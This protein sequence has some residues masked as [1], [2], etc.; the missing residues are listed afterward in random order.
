KD[1]W[2]YGEAIAGVP[3]ALF[4]NGLICGLS[5]TDDE[6]GD[7]TTFIGTIPAT[8]VTGMTMHGFWGLAD[9]NA[10]A[11]AIAGVS[12][13]A[14]VDFALSMRAIG[15]AAGGRL[16]WRGAGVFEMVLTT[17]GVVVGAYESSFSRR[18]Q[19]PW[20]FLTAWSGAL[21]LHGL[22]SAIVNGHDPKK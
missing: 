15:R 10:P 6:M 16:H 1:S 4:F 13:L 5:A 19:G 3:Q 22:V 21:M 17:P 20:I 12:A 8:V 11:D 9:D 18:Q 14:G 2:L 7:V